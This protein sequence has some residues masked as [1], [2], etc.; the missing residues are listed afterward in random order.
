[1]SNL[2]ENLNFQLPTLVR[3]LP[4]YPYWLYSLS[5]DIGQYFSKLLH[6]INKKVYTLSQCSPAKFLQWNLDIVLDFP[7]NDVRCRLELFCILSWNA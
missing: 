1:M 3:M 4:Q 5:I 2:Q 7:R 6:L